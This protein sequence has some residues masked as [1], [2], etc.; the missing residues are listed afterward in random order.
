MEFYQD[1]LGF[2]VTFVS[3]S[4]GLTEI[5]SGEIK[6]VLLKRRNFK[7]LLTKHTLMSYADNNHV[8]LSFTVSNL[9]EVHKQLKSQGIT[10]ISDES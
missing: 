10:I 2:E 8:A 7:E 4:N 9:Y 6:L 5:K 3:E 1:I